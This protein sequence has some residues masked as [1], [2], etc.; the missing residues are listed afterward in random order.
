MSFCSSKAFNILLAK[1]GNVYRDN[2]FLYSFEQLGPELYKPN[3][4][5][6]ILGYYVHTCFYVF[7]LY[8]SRQLLNV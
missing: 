3:L 5:L 1:N 6:N 2:I 8:T 4:K 7:R